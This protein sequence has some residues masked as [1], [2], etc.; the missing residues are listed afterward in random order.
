MRRFSIGFTVAVA[1]FAGISCRPGIDQSRSARTTVAP[2]A[3]NPRTAEDVDRIMTELSN[4]GRWG[5]DDQLG[6]TNLITPETRRRALAEVREGYVVSMSHNVV[7]V[8]QDGV[9]PFEHKMLATGRT[10]GAGGTADMY[11]VRYHG[12]SQTHLDAICH[13]FYKGRMYNGFSQEEVTEAGAGKLSVI[14][15]KNGLC[16]RAVLMD[17]PGCV[18]RST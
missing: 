15:F 3:A 2:D 7:K 13:S 11:S 1:V 16:T 5:K 4:W 9:A 14:N 6:T 12:F 18:D 17:I 8:E 10:P